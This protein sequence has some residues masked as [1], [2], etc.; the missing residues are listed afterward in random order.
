MGD[1]DIGRVERKGRDGE[2]DSVTEGV[3]CKDTQ[4]QRDWEEER[5][6]GRE[7]RGW[8]AGEREVENEKTA[9]VRRTEMQ[10]RKNYFQAAG[11]RDRARAKISRGRRT[12]NTQQDA[13][14][15]RGREH[16]AKQKN[17]ERKKKTTQQTEREPDRTRQQGRETEKEKTGTKG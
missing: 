4:K 6:S 13:A 9:M 7:R 17:E 8:R 14:G 15:V 5:T 11:Q 12:G 2:Q 1:T 10:R 3:E 16:R